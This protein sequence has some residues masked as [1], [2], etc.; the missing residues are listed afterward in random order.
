MAS[1][2]SRRAL[3]KFG[4]AMAVPL[5]LIGGLFLWKEDSLG[6]YLIA[7]A[8]LFLISGLFFPGLLRPVERVWMKLSERLSVLNTYVILTLFYFLVVTPT[9]LLV[10][11]L[12]KDL[13]NLKIKPR[14]QSYWLPVDSDGPG[15]RHHKPY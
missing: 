4:F 14:E 7:L 8:G 12:G 2:K 11:L 13:L 1:G 10:R 5:A 3:R 15:S 6:L 9:A